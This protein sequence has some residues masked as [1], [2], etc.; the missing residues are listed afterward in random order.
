VR[1]DANG[2]PLSLS[3][4]AFDLAPELVDAVDAAWVNDDQVVVLGRSGEEPLRPVLA[5]VGGDTEPLAPTPNA[6]SIASALGERNIVVGTA[7]GT[8]LRRSGSLWLDGP[9][10][11]SP[12]FG[13]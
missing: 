8:V 12:A 9:F 5:R 1:S 2:R 3:Q 11:V 4:A 6:V 7:D 13:G 10:G